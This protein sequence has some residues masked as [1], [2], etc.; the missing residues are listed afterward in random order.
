M[1]LL[2]N[3]LQKRDVIV[4]TS[5]ACSSKQTKTS[6]V[7]EALR[8]DERFKNGV[9]RIS[10]GAH[11]TDEEIA[12][13]KQEFTEVMKELK[14]EIITMIWKEI[15]IRYGELSTKG[16]NKKDFISRLRENIRHAFT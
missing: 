10:F 7:V 11:N 4:S 2:I 1:K 6:H 12:Q 5:S 9:I 3:A 16:R 8:I 15:L 13:F 14:G